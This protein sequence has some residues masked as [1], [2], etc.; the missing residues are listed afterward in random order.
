MG[1]AQSRTGCLS[2]ATFLHPPQTDNCSGGAPT[3][4]WYQNAQALTGAQAASRTAPSD[5]PGASRARASAA[6]SSTKWRRPAPHLR[7]RRP[8][9]PD[10][11]LTQTISP[12]FCVTP[13]GST[14][15][16]PTDSRAFSL[17][18]LIEKSG[19][20]YEKV[21]SAPR[22]NL[23]SRTVVRWQQRHAK[24]GV[25]AERAPPDDGAHI[26]DVGKRTC[27]QP[28]HTL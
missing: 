23:S 16:T 25:Q 27:Q 8:S 18:I 19:L 26:R 22:I 28:P 11:A 17:I 15:A 6:R 10:G 20:A 21:G 14:L 13:R 2:S 4:F 1:S 12:R 7:S 24:A 9:L 3:A 5:G